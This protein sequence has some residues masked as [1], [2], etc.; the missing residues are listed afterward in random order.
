VAQVYP[1]GSCMACQFDRQVYGIEIVFAKTRARPTAAA[2]IRAASVSNVPH[3]SHP[4]RE[5]E[6]QQCSGCCRSLP[7]LE[8]TVSDALQSFR[9]ASAV[10]T[11]G[12]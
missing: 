7:A 2:G 4:I 9:R 6:R 1:G 8:L 3:C 11:T 10:A 5:I 12:R